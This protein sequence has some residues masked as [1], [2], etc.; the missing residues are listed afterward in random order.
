MDLPPSGEPYVDVVETHTSILVFVGDLV[1]KGK[2]PVTFPF[3]DL[4]TAGKR[5]ENCRR[6][7]EL[8]R[9][10]APDDLPRAQ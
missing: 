1:Y 2:K 7:L 3:L 9:L 5:L 8:N 6:E 10:V 4:S